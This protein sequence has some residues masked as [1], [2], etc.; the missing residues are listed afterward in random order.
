MSIYRSNPSDAS[1][2]DATEDAATNDIVFRQVHIHTYMYM[3]IHIRIYT[4]IHIYVYIC[5]IQP[6]MISSFGR[7]IHICTCIYIYV[8]ICKY[9]HI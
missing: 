1:N 7:F 3:Y 8:Y 9:T 5:I 6:P 2:P 4:N